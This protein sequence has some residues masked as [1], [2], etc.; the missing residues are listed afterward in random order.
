MAEKTVKN[1]DIIVLSSPTTGLMP[2]KAVRGGR[3]VDESGGHAVIMDSAAWVQT[4]SGV[5][6]PG[7]I[8][9]SPI[10]DYRTRYVGIEYADGS[11]LP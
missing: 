6:S 7:K 4:P 11:S 1:S 8:V 10:I 3:Y 9:V 5:S 2:V